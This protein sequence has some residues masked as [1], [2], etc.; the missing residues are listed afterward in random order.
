MNMSQNKINNTI[1]GFNNTIIQYQNDSTHTPSNQNHSDKY[2]AKDYCSRKK[3]FGIAVR[4]LLSALGVVAD[5][6]TITQVCI[7][8]IIKS[9]NYIGENTYYF[10]LIPLILSSCLAVIL[11]ALTKYELLVITRTHQSGIYRNIY[12]SGYTYKLYPNKCPICG[13][14]IVIRNSNG[15]ITFKCTRSKNH[16]KEVDITELDNLPLKQE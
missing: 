10:Y 8:I 13:A 2:S 14:R 5:I 3:T 7:P 1:N 16:S 12:S 9:L 15:T 6:I 4:F 11:A